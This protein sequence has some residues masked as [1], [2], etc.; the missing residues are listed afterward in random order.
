MRDK[1][2]EL[3]MENSKTILAN[4]LLLMNGA[5]VEWPPRDVYDKP[6]DIGCQVVGYS[7][8]CLQDF[9]VFIVGGLRLQY[10]GTRLRWVVC[11]YEDDGRYFESWAED[12]R[13]L[14]STRVLCG[15]SEVMVIDE[16]LAE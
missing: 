1:D 12:C 13:V 15:A 5:T 11:A 10:R 16:L 2:V 8:M 9:H 3:V 4:G 6:I 7:T 14:K